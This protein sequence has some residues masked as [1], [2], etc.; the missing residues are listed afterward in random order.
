MGWWPRWHLALPADLEGAAAR[1][2]DAR[3]EVD[4]GAGAGSGPV[5][6][7]RHLRPVLHALVEATAAASGGWQLSEGQG[8]PAQAWAGLQTLLTGDSGGAGQPGGRGD[9]RAQAE[10]KAVA[11]QL[12]GSLRQAWGVAGGGCGGAEGCHEE[13]AGVAVRAAALAEGPTEVAAAAAEAELLQARL[14]S[15]LS[16]APGGAE[17]WRWPLWCCYPGCT[18]IWE[19]KEPRLKTCAC[20]GGCGARYCDRVCQ[21]QAWRRY[22][23]GT[24]LVAKGWRSLALSRVVKE[25]CR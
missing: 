22:S 11:R 3:A 19:D 25:L 16:E 17:E 14:L 8:G 15:A 7:G 20:G 1:V 24:A 6:L 13:P 10:V 18:S 4:Q 2:E 5:W 23:T 9:A 21:E 12:L